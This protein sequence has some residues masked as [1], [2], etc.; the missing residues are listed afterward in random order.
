VKDLEIQRLLLDNGFK[1]APPPPSA[2]WALI[3]E[4]EPQQSLRV[5]CALGARGGFVLL[6][7]SERERQWLVE[8]LATTSVGA[9]DVRAERMEARAPWLAVTVGVGA[10]ALFGWVMSTIHPFF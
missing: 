6:V 1:P 9:V 8:R 4:F 10:L 3:G 7:G 5:T 2:R